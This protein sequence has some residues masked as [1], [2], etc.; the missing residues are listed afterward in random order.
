[1]SSSLRSGSSPAVEV[2]AWGAAMA[3]LSGLV[4]ALDFK[5][6]LLFTGALLG[7]L[8]YLGIAGQLLVGLVVVRALLD[9]L[10]QDSAVGGLP[11]AQA[12][13]GGLTLAI[14]IRL[15]LDLR[16]LNELPV[17]RFF[18]AWGVL[19]MVTGLRNPTLGVFAAQVKMIGPPVFVGFAMATTYQQKDDLYRCLVPMTLVGAVPLLGDVIAYL[20]GQVVF[21]Q[22]IARYT[23]LYGESIHNASFA[24][25]LFS[26]M[27]AFWAFAGRTRWQRIGGAVMA[28]I[29]V[30]AVIYAYVRTGMMGVISLIIAFLLLE[31]RMGVLAIVF[32][33]GATSLTTSAQL[34]ERFDDIVVFLSEED[35]ESEEEHL[36]SGRLYIWEQSFTNYRRT[37][38][39][40]QVFGVGLQRHQTLSPSGS[41]DTHNDYLGLLFQLGPIGLLVYLAMQIQIVRLAWWVRQRTDEHFVWHFTNLV[42]ALHAT[43]FVTNNLSNAFVRRMLPSWYL[44]ALSGLLIGVYVRMQREKRASTEQPAAL[45]SR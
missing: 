33:I 31:R 16:K 37:E 34:Q 5:T 8:A 13:T 14:G 36:G 27:G 20:R 23:G 11:I 9:L 15:L 4:L 28:L 22:D 12:I 35:R 6:M 10:D 19:V 2:L 38:P 3:V 40:E 21:L 45:A 1:M 44:W 29:S 17:G 32:A 18:L 26:A 42:I 41:H 24:F 25:L 30:P 39:F 43:S 7:G